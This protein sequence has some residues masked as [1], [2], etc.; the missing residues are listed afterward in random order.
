MVFIF[1]FMSVLYGKRKQKESRQKEFRINKTRKKKEL[2]IQSSKSNEP[3]IQTLEIHV[4]LLLSD[5][6]SR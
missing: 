2:Q 1:F 3:S 4:S 5:K 6:L